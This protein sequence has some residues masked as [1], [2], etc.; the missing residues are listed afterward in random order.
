M[1]DKENIYI[2]AGIVLI[3]D[4]IIKLIITHSLKLYQVIKVIPHFFSICYVK[5]TGAAF[6]IF[7]N[8]TLFLTI[9][10][11][12]VIIILDIMIRKEKNLTKG[13]CIALGL[14]MG[15]IFGNLVDRILRHYVID[16]LSFRIIRYDFPIFNI[17]DI[18]ITVG[19]G[20]LII[21][22]FFEKEDKKLI[23]NKK[24][25]GNVKLK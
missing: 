7:E 4:Q 17:A 10:S 25:D 12:I 5:N 1:K 23:K 16:F 15:G 20:L 14:I 11:I 24:G 2:T 9:I 13:N 8:N 3:I 19:V 18:G 6:S 22:L 21:S